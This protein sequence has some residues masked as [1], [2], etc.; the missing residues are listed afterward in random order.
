MPKSAVTEDERSA[1]REPSGNGAP[2]YLQLTNM[3]VPAWGYGGPVRLLF[4][5]ARWLSRDFR[6]VALTGDVH[7][8]F[9]RMAEKS[10]TLEGVRIHRHKVF[11]PRLAKKSI[12]L[13]SPGMFVRAAQ[14]IRS[15]RGPCIVHFSELRGLV[16]LYALFL[17]LLFIFPS[18]ILNGK[19]NV[20]G[21]R[22]SRIGEDSTSSFAE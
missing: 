4:D 21:V 3:Y 20:G 18:T 10:E 7:H 22:T 19:A 5:Y 1:I 12:Y 13:L 15:A 14:E 17:K 2:L 6:V 11:F 16:A 8:D 9:T